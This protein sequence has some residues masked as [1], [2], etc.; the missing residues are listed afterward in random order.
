M[1]DGGSKDDTASL[2]SQAGAEVIAVRGGEAERLNEAARAA[3]GQ[4]LLFHESG[5]LLPRGYEAEA[6]ETLQSGDCRLGAFSLPDHVSA[7]RRALLWAGN[8][9]LCTSAFGL[10]LRQ[11]I[12]CPRRISVAS[13]GFSVKVGEGR[14]VPEL[15]RRMSALGRT[16]IH[17]DRISFPRSEEEEKPES[18]ADMLDSAENHVRSYLGRKFA[19][20]TPPPDESDS[21][22]AKR[23]RSMIAPCDHCGECTRACPMLARHRIDLTGMVKAPLLAWHCFPV[24]HLR[25][26]AHAGID[27]VA[28]P[29]PA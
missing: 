24:R 12:S 16:V 9:I 20:K 29:G 4:I 2:A 13:G 22:L 10:S 17:N 6:W 15:I 8:S 5:S 28:I 3:R 14:A 23:I 1:A 7:F 27:G 19:R 21:D 18:I 11:G 25:A 26:S